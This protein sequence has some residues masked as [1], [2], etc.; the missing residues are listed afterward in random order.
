MKRVVIIGGGPAGILA[1]IKIKEK[2]LD[3]IEVIIIEKMNRI[4]KKIIVSGNGKCNL[5]NTLC[6][7]DYIYNSTF[8]KDIYQRYDSNSLRADLLKMGLFTKIDEKMRVYPVTESSSTVMDLLL[9]QLNKY[10]VKLITNTQVTQVTK[11]RQLF[12]IYT[13]TTTF[14]ADYVVFATGGTSSKIHG[15]SGDGYHLLKHFNVKI[16]PIKPGLVGLKIKEEQIKGLDGLR[17]KAQVMIYDQDQLIFQEK[18]EIQF[19]KDGIS[20]IVIMNASSILARFAR[21]LTIVLDFLEAFDEKE[22]IKK[23]KMIK[24]ANPNL[25]LSDLLHGLL[26]KSL[27]DK[28][29]NKLSKE[30]NLSIETFVRLAKNYIVEVIDTYGFDNSQVTVGGISQDEIDDNFEL[31]KV[32]FAYAIG[33]LLDVDGIC[34]GFNMH[35]AFASGA[36]MG[37]KLAERIQENHEANE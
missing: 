15:S 11:E 12:N 7:D 30:K 31:K 18:G 28:I 2:L 19:K 10:Q 32:P 29:S 27:A 21:S 5:S 8:A 14:K 35:F 23:L 22:L 24:L 17:Q 13:T 26:P 4:G 1:A 6:E 37:Q 16:T 34:G 33:E 9:L 20:G 25:P 36:I 3:Q